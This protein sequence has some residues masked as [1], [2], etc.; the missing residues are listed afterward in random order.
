MSLYQQIKDETDIEYLTQ[1]D[2]YVDIDI[3]NIGAEGETLLKMKAKM[4]NLTPEAFLEKQRKE[5]NKL[6]QTIQNRINELR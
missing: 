3:A 5:L 6:K 2:K 1:L 4:H